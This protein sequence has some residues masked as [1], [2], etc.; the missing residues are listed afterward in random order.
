M[1]SGKEAK[2]QGWRE[3]KG[4]WLEAQDDLVVSWAVLCVKQTVRR[5]CRMYFG[6]RKIDGNGEMTRGGIDGYGAAGKSRVVTGLRSKG[7]RRA[8]FLSRVFQNET[9]ARGSVI[10]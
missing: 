10:F 8:G 5:K 2:V 3:S 6:M 1:G 7:A 9:Y 4:Q